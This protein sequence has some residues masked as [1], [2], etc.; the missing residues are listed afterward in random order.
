MRNDR[1]VTDYYLFYATNE[2]RG[3]QKMKEAMWKVDTTGE[4]SFSDATDSSQ[5]V[6]FAE[7]AFDIL[8]DQIL[9]RFEGQEATVA[10]VERFVLAETAFR[11][12]H[13]KRQVLKLLEAGDV[14]LLEV[15]NPPAGRRNGTYG[16][17]EMTLRFARLPG[18]G[19]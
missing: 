17:P 6:L 9:K 16:D 7:A 18:D 1:D 5:Q 8:R 12:T 4:F 3:L 10:E 2:I 14:P 11:E 15:L 19:H 13:H